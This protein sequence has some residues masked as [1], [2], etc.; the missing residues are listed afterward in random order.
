MSIAKIESLSSVRLTKVNL[1]FKYLQE[2]RLLNE[3]EDG[4]EFG[5]FGTKLVES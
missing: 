2:E 5:R 3:Q 1:F 4:H